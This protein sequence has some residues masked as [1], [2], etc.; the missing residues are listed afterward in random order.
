MKYGYVRVSAKSKNL[1]IQIEALKKYEVDE[2]YEEKMSAQSKKKSEFKK[3]ISHLKTGDTLVVYKLDRLGRTVKQLLQLAEEFQENGINFV[4]I[5]EN[6]DTSTTTGKFVFNI[7][8]ELAQ[9]ERNLISE[10]TIEGL[11]SAKEKG[12][13]PGR[14]PVEDKKLD[15]AFRMYYSND[16][17]IK[18]IINATGI[19]KSTLYKY[20]NQRKD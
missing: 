3:L 7:F 2:I 9:M 19:A 8:C 15:M 16:Y 17:L 14:P 6:L 11:K 12:R 13:T 10:R 5:K 20:L 1:D 4:S 18:E